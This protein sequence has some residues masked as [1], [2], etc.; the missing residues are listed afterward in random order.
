[1]SLKTQAQTLVT[2]GLLVALGDIA[3]AQVTESVGT[4]ALGMGGAFVAVASDS[5]ATWWN[6]GAMPAGPF[7]D[8]SLAGAMTQAGEVLPTR[9]DDTTGVA[10][11]TPPLGMSYY[12]FQVTD[13]RPFDPTGGDSGDREQRRA[14][15]PIRSLSASQVGVTLVH[16]LGSGIHVGTTLKYMRGT[17][18]TARGDSL[19]SADE[20]LDEGEAL[21]GGDAGN[22]FDLDAGLLAI[23]G[24]FRVGGVVRNLSAPSFSAGTETVRL[25]RQGRLGVA[26]DAEAAGGAPFI[27]SLDADVNRTST[28]TGERRNVAFGAE[29]WLWAK[30]V[31]VRGGGRVNTVGRQ[32]RTATAGVSVAPRAGLFL[33]AYGARGGSADDRGWGFG[34][35]VSF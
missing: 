25:P 23:L 16:S 5:S 1:M 10:L 33:E 6:P 8:L 13:I 35:R 15:V 7:V 26:F 19:H 27:L 17:V 18:R 12:R 3:F 4:R 9:R 32:E 20:L 29:R 11:L 28:G 31:G 21:E 24:G 2:A 14:G 34:A 22:Q 30:R